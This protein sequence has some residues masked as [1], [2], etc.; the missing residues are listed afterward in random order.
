MRHDLILDRG[1]PLTV[2]CWNSKWSLERLKSGKQK[3]RKEKQQKR[4]EF[5][6]RKLFLYVAFLAAI[7]TIETVR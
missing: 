3:K 7:P 6:R 1:G 5:G 2:L 4:A